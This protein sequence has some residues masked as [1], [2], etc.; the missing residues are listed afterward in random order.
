ML[1][2]IDE[3]FNEKLEELAVSENHLGQIHSLVFML[4]TIFI[5]LIYAIFCLWYQRHKMNDKMSLF[6][7]FILLYVGFLL[8]EINVYICYRFAMYFTI[9][10]II[11]LSETFVELT[12][13]DRLYSG[14]LYFRAFVVILPFVFL[15]GQ[16]QVSR[17][18][19]YYPYSSVLERRVDN[20]REQ[21]GMDARGRF[22]HM[23][24][25]NEY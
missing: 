25:D 16:R 20:Y 24:N 5:Y 13:S 21:R 11:Y 22:W 23:P 6:E 3:S 18:Y 2:D 7:P 9:Y 14:T 4:K 19:L 10:F 8:L 12:K 17:S 1:L 15:V